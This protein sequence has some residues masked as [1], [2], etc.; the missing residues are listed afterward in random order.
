MPK[1][2]IKQ[3]AEDLEIIK[4]CGNNDEILAQRHFVQYKIANLITSC[5]KDFSNFPTEIF[6]EKLEK[7]GIYVPQNYNCPNIISLKFND[8][9]FEIYKHDY[10]GTAYLRFHYAGEKSIEH[11][12]CISPEKLAEIIS[13]MPKMLNDWLE[14]DYLEVKKEAQKQIK[15]LRITQVSA[16]LMLENLLKNLGADYRICHSEQKND[17]W[18]KISDCREIHVAISYNNFITEIGKI[19]GII[20]DFSNFIEKYPEIIEITKSENK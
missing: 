2:I 19:P 7:F 13:Q 4:L 14:N 8:I 3:I 12:I 20:K 10:C 15:Q 17:V 18:I 6:I 5:D 16:Q 9:H 1:E 11:K